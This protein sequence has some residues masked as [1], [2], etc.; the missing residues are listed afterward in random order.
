MAVIKKN[1]N[2]Y[3]ISFVCRDAKSSAF[4]RLY[5]DDE[6]VG[7]MVFIDDSE[8]V[9]PNK[10]SKDG[11][12]IALIFRFNRL[13]DIVA[14]LENHKPDYIWFNDEDKRGGFHMHPESIKE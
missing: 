9:Q 5:Q 10:L 6:L 14:I 12:R 1:F 3:K 11:T 2:R 4:I 13:K 7:M 8:A